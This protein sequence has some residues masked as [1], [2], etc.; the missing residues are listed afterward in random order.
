MRRPACSRWH[1]WAK[2]SNVSV[3][4]EIAGRRRYVFQDH[5]VIE[6]IGGEN[7]DPMIN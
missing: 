1:D 2:R 3:Q 5:P 7:V 6:D 4:A